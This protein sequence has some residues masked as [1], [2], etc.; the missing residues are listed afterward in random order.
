MMANDGIG[1]LIVNPIVCT[2][3]QPVFIYIF[4]KVAIDG[5]NCVMK[6][7]RFSL[8]FLIELR[9]KDLVCVICDARL[10]CSEIDL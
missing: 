2:D 3:V 4:F 5:W 8:V 1:Q 10:I 6:M 9:V 7:M